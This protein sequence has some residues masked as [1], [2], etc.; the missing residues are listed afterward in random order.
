VQAFGNREDVVGKLVPKLGVV[1]AGA[2]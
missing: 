1:R 2:A